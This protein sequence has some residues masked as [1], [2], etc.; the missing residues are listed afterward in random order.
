MLRPLRDTCQSARNVESL[1]E[2]FIAKK[3]SLAVFLIIWIASALQATSCADFV[4]DI[5][6]LSSDLDCRKK[7]MEWFQ[8]ID[9]PIDF[10]DCAIPTLNK[11]PVAANEFERMAQRC[12]DGAPNQSRRTRN[13]RARDR[14]EKAG[15]VITTQW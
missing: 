2:K 13:R 15:I 12:G 8:S 1:F 6:Q 3:D 9:C 4:L 14:K 5:D 7:A 11:W 10:S